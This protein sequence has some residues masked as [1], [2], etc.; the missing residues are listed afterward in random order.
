MYIKQLYEK[1][2]MYDRATLNSHTGGS[3]V[4]LDIFFASA[5]LFWSLPHEVSVSIE[6]LQNIAGAHKRREKTPLASS[7]IALYFLVS[8]IK[9]QSGE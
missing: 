7:T 8:F 3:P 9:F 5:I 2:K 1:E 6:T 4:Q